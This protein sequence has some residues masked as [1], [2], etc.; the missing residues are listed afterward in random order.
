MGIGEYDEFE[1]S[2]GTKWQISLG[3]GVM[4]ELQQCAF[5]VIPQK[6]IDEVK[7]A[8]A[9]GKD[10][11]KIKSDLYDS[12]AKEANEGGQLLENFGRMC[13]MLA[14]FVRAYWDE[15]KQAWVSI[16]SPGP[17]GTRDRFYWCYEF[18]P[19]TDGNELIRY[20]MVFLVKMG[21][22]VADK[23]KLRASFGLATGT[24]EAPSTPTETSPASQG[25][26]SSS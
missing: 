6:N 12:L 11:D 25:T 7:E 15:D 24:K 9:E 4:T 2:N 1:T 20:A 22:G 18:M 10:V 21:K 23:G 17:M 26:L 16:G 8:I 5:G 14:T 13:Q 19:S 3:Y